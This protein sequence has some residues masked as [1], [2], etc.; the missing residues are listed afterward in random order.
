MKHPVY[1]I[2]FGES[3]FIQPYYFYILYEINAKLYGHLVEQTIFHTYKTENPTSDEKIPNR[4]IQ[5][6]SGREKDTILRADE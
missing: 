2:I 4:K 3:Y 5:D 1:S 6:E